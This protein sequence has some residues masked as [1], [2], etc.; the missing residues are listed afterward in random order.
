MFIRI[1]IDFRIKDLKGNSV[2]HAV[3]K[4]GNLKV[5]ER[6]YK[7]VDSLEK[8]NIFLCSD[9]NSLP[10]AESNTESLN[11]NPIS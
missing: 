9:S 5:F 6:L 4:R 7:L 10:F 1:G 2:L 11:F 8:Q 3:A